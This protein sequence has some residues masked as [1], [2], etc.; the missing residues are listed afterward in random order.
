MSKLETECMNCVSMK[1]FLEA[2]V[3]RINSQSQGFCLA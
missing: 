2:R 3:L 1:R